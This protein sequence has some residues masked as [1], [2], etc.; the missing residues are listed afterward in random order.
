MTATT[1]DEV[2]RDDHDAIIVAVQT[3][4]L[5]DPEMDGLMDTVASQRELS[6]SDLASQVLGFWL[7]AIRSDLTLGSTATMEQSLP[8][9][10]SFRSGHDLR[11]GNHVVLR[12][13]DD[14]SDEIEARLQ[15]EALRREYEAYR[16]KVVEL[17]T[18]A[19]PG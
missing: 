1:M 18:A 13:F 5:R 9:L 7:Q 3:R 12:M 17:I 8:W 6:K 4:M 11:F 19:F 10:I 15:S 16:Q 2:L 14:I